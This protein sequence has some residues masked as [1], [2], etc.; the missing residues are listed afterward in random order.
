ME[1][2][3]I[4]ENCKELYNDIEVEYEDIYRSEANQ[5]KMVKLYAIILKTREN[6]LFNM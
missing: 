5:L 3:T 4:M 2:R 6:L 1:C